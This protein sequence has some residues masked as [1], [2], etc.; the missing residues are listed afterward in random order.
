MRLTKRSQILVYLF[1]LKIKLT[2]KTIGK[3][4]NKNVAELKTITL[5][6]HKIR[7]YKFSPMNLNGIIIAWLHFAIHIICFLYPVTFFVFIICA[8]DFA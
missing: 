4:R 2:I 1:S 7:K 3:K 6:P 8:T 5:N